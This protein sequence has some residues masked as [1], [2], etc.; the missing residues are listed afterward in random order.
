MS[1]LSSGQVYTKM[2][3]LDRHALVILLDHTLRYL[4]QISIDNQLILSQMRDEFT[5]TE[6]FLHSSNA[7][8]ISTNYMDSRKLGRTNAN[9]IK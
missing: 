6:R 3:L 4:H 5:P 1:G 8:G 2:N 9:A 7:T